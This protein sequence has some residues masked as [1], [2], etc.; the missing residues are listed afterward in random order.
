MGTCVR[1]A[2][3]GWFL[4]ALTLLLSPP[5]LSHL[6]SSSVPPLSVVWDVFVLF[7]VFSPLLSCRLA[8]LSSSSSAVCFLLLLRFFFSSCHAVS[9]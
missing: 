2:K 7:F 8:R 4:R 3:I 6:L 5:S 9:S 1:E